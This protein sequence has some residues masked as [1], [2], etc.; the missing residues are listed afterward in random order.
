M[1]ALVSAVN[2]K[3]D[4]KMQA[5]RALSYSH[6]SDAK[7]R[8]NRTIVTTMFTTLCKR[9][10]CGSRSFNDDICKVNCDSLDG[11]IAK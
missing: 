3:L 4:N 10:G 1:H 5:L 2:D 7:V 11:E 9:H 8:Q 6:K